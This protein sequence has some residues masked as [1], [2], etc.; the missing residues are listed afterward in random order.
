MVAARHALP[1]LAAT[2]LAVT[3]LIVSPS[4]STQ[5]VGCL[6]TQGRLSQPQPA[7][8]RQSVSSD[9]AGIT[10]GLRLRGGSLS[11]SM[12]RQS[13]LAA[14]SVSC[15]TP[16]LLLVPLSLILVPIAALGGPSALMLAIESLVPLICNRAITIA[17][18]F[19]AILLSLWSQ[20][21]FGEAG[22][23]A[24]RMLQL[25]SMLVGGITGVL[26]AFVT[27][28]VAKLQR[29]YHTQDSW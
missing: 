29:A 14:V 10:N 19:C 15:F 23:M 4:P 22:S 20:A 18:L 13:V 9:V 21:C 28:V 5:H 17:S 12:A 8:H 1:Y 16:L 7:R 26:T 24:P 6:M 2:T 27:P 25:Q 3:A 11:A